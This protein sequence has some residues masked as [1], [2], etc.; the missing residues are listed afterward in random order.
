M[1]KLCTST[2][3]YSR[4]LRFYVLRNCIKVTNSKKEEG[5]SWTFFFISGKIRWEGRVIYWNKPCGEH[6]LQHVA[7]F[8]IIWLFNSFSSIINL[9]LSWN[10][11]WCCLETWFLHVTGRELQRI[12]GNMTAKVGYLSMKEVRFAG[13]AS[14]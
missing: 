12:S 1:S 11:P 8:R 13:L 5:A 6:H 3:M 2:I 9:R 7:S 4:F 14:Q 10:Y